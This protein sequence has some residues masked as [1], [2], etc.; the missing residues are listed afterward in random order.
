MAPKKKCPPAGK[1]MKP[2]SDVEMRCIVERALQE[3]DVRRRVHEAKR[4]R[5]DWFGS[6]FGLGFAAVGVA[7]LIFRV[8]DAKVPAIIL[9]VFGAAVFDRR[10]VV[11][12]LRARFS[13]NGHTDE[14]RGADGD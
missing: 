11:S 10:A 4:V 13:N 14:Y 3:H 5:R 6:L 9:I 1:Q 2:R 12:T 7:L 8:P